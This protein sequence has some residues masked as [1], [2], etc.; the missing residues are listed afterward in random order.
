MR[1]QERTWS[2]ER[3]GTWQREEVWSSEARARR[4]DGAR[5]WGR[6]RVS[7]TQCGSRGESGWEG[8]A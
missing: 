2:A 4:G 1:L 3:G 8:Q 7:G 5:A 6:D